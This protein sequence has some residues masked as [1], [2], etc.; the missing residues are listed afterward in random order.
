LLP[1][2]FLL[3]ENFP[4]P[5]F[6]MIAELEPQIVYT[7]LAR[8]APHLTGRRTPDWRLYLEAQAAGFDA[9]VT[10]DQ[11]QLGQEHELVA[12]M[13]TT[14]SVVTWV[15]AIEDPI[16]EWAQL[17]AYGRHVLRLMENR[18]P[19]IILLPEPRLDN[20]H[21]RRANAKLSGVAAHRKIPYQDLRTQALNFMRRELAKDDLD[22]LADLLANTPAP[23][24]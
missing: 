24:G 18:G 1:K 10:R 8:F 15:R 2:R 23:A 21:V 17:L 19:C 20:T 22:H 3:D 7:P 14:V 12:L 13:R 6:P 5:V 4:D 9:V 11:S 16:V